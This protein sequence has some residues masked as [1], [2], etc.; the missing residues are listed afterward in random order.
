MCQ[1][2]PPEPVHPTD[3]LLDSL[4]E[5]GG[6]VGAGEAEVGSEVSEMANHLDGCGGG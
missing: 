3:G 4:P 5:G 2:E 6:I 1:G